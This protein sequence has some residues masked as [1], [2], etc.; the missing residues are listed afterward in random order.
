MSTVCTLTLTILKSK[1]KIYLG[2]PTFSVQSLGIVFDAAGFVDS[3]LITIH[4][5]SDCGFAVDNILVSLSRNVCNCDFAVV[6]NGA[7][8]SLLWV[9]HFL[10]PIKLT[11]G[12]TDIHPCVRQ[13]IFVIDVKIRKLTA[14][15]AEFPEI[16]NILHQRDAGQGPLQIGRKN[17]TVIGTVEKTVDVVENILFTDVFTVLFPGSFENELRNPVSANLLRLLYTF[18]QGGVLFGSSLII[19]EWKA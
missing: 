13:H 6:E 7:R 3:D 2:L 16:P 14:C 10:Y 12:T 11:L 18:K 17:F 19:V 1:S 4:Y 15:F 9:T 5:P 8:L